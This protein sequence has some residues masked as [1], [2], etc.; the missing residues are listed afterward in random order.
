MP[1]PVHEHKALVPA[2]AKRKHTRIDWLTLATT[3]HDGKPVTWKLERGVDWNSST[4]AQVVEMVERFVNSDAGK[5]FTYEFDKDKDTVW[6]RFT[7][8][9]AEHKATGDPFAPQAHV[10]A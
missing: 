2:G 1:T 3:L 10:N 5:D 9:P 4:S 6:V 7:R 8:K